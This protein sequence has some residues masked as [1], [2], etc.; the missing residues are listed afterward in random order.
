MSSGPVDL[1]F[2]PHGSVDEDAVNGTAV[3]GV[4]AGVKSATCDGYTIK[5]VVA[6]TG[7]NP[8]QV[9]TAAERLVSESHVFAVVAE[10][11]LTF[12]AARPH[13]RSATS[14]SRVP[15]ASDERCQA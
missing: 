15:G 10:S 7:T 11:A 6:D 3:K 13:G 14:P 4:A 1:D 9:L 8:L 2:R 5:Y 12:S